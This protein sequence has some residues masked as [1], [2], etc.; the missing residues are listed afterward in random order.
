MSPQELAAV[1]AGATADN[2][3]RARAGTLRIDSMVVPIC[4]VCGDHAAFSGWGDA[5]EWGLTHRW[6]WCQGPGEAA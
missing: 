1:I 4:F 5:V 6:I 3:G 2:A